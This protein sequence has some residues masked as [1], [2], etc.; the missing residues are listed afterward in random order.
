MVENGYGAH[1]ALRE[2]VQYGVAQRGHALVPG[3]G[4]GPEQGQRLLVSRDHAGY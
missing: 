4:A 2:T 1:V 3:V